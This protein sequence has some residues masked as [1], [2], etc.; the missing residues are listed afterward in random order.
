MAFLF[1]GGV[2]AVYWLVLLTFGVLLNA[3]FLQLAMKLVCRRHYVYRDACSVSLKVILCVAAAQMLIELV[4]L[5]LP[6]FLQWLLMLT[7]LVTSFGLAGFLYGRLIMSR[8]GAP[9]GLKRGFLIQLTITVCYIL[10]SI[11]VI[12]INVVITLAI[13]LE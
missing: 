2:L 3:W 1:S 7:V 11:L 5:F 4:G 9:I 8:R 13:T 12:I 6:D 10:M